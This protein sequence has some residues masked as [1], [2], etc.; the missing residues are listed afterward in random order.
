MY[1]DF[2]SVLFILVTTPQPINMALNKKL[3]YNPTVE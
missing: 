3:G 2:R 1:E